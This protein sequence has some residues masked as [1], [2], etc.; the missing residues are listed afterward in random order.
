MQAQRKWQG[1]KVAGREPRELLARWGLTLTLLRGAP[2]SSCLIELCCAV[3]LRGL[4][5]LLLLLLR[6][7]GLL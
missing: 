7:R 4:R 3:H 1:R 6:V 2:C 5:L